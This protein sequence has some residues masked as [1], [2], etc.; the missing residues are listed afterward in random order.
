MFLTREEL[1]DFYKNLRY[2]EIVT[3]VQDL[4]DGKMIENMISTSIREFG[5]KTRENIRA[6]LMRD[7][8]IEVSKKYYW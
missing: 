7:T 2:G 3:I 1:E 4:S 6:N 8:I 5:P